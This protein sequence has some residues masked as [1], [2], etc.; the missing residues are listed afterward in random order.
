MRHGGTSATQ[1]CGVAGGR[2]GAATLKLVML[3]LLQDAGGRVGLGERTQP[4]GRTGWDGEAEC[5]DSSQ[6]FWSSGRCFSSSMGNMRFG[7][8]S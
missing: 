3:I 7:E 2:W 1:T 5:Q 6:A 8:E 4:S